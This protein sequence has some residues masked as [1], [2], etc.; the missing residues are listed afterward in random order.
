MKSCVIGHL[1]GPIQMVSMSN[2]WLT[3]RS[4]LRWSDLR[5]HRALIFT[6]TWLISRHN[7]WGRST[8]ER[9]NSSISEA[10]LI[11]LIGL[12]DRTM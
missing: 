12:Y 5:G 1:L 11:F 9:L 4:R 8:L 6:A 2:R 10:P 7:S 3:Q